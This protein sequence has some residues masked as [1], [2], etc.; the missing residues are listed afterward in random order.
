[1]GIKADSINIISDEKIDTVNNAII[2]I[3]D[4]SFTKNGAYT[5]IMGLD[6]LEHENTIGKNK[7]LANV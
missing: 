6:M 4:K 7:V 5:A 1:M 3:Y 2:G